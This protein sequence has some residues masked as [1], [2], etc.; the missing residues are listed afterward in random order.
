MYVGWQVPRFD[1]VWS[2]FHMES[3]NIQNIHHIHM[4][5][6]LWCIL[7]AGVSHEKRKESCLRSFHILLYRWCL[8]L[9][10][11]RLGND[12]DHIYSIELQITKN[13]SYTARSDSWLD[14]HINPGFDFPILNFPY[15][16]S[17]NPAALAYGVYISQLIVYGLWSLSWFYCY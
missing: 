11:S 13:T 17:N 4:T 14:L 1:T 9:N 6:V 3:L 5:W 7:H 12:V 15:I 10:N 16:F 2:L 8:S